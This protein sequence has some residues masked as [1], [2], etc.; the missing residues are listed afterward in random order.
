VGQHWPLARLRLGRLG[1]A[2]FLAHAGSVYLQDTA[3]REQPPWK[4][5]TFTATA[6]QRNETLDT[7]EKANDVIEWAFR[8]IGGVILGGISLLVLILMSGHVSLYL[9]IMAFGFGSGVG[10]FFGHLIAR[11]ISH[12]METRL[13]ERGELTEVEAEWSLLT[14]TLQLVFDSK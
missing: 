5:Y 3:Y 11:K 13:E 1:R 14:E 12:T 9:I 7:T 10:G 4:F 2:P 6:A 8:I